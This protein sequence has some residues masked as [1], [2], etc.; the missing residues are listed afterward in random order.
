[1]G[2]RLGRHGR[3]AR[4]AL[5]D[6]Y[7]E[8]IKPRLHILADWIRLQA[9]DA[10]TRAAV[11]TASPE[12][13]RWWRLTLAYSHWWNEDLDSAAFELGAEDAAT[14]SAISSYA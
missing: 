4:Y 8:H 6:D 12:N 10:Q 9:P 14:S 11:D 2:R 13:E 5:G 1:M 3:V 7:H